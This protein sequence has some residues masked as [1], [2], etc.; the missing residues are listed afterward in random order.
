MTVRIPEVGRVFRSRRETVT[1][2]S[3]LEFG[4]R[5]DPQAMH[6]DEAAAREGFFGELVA[7]GWQTAVT[8]MRLVVECDLFDGAPMIGL[9]VRSL[10]FEAPVRPGDELRAEAEITHARR[11]GGGRV[12]A[13]VRVRTLN[14]GGTLVLSQEWVVLAVAPGDRAS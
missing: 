3:V 10:K 7:S 2:E 13:G 5:N 6:T 4:S 9:E 14:A 1:R 8:T 11:T 12:L